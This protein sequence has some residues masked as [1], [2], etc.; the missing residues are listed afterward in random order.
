M[1]KDINEIL[2]E[3]ASLP[4]KKENDLSCAGQG[5][6]KRKVFI[7]K[8][9]WAV[10]SVAL[11]LVIGLGVWLG[12]SLGK[13]SDPVVRYLTDSDY[14]I[15]AMEHGDFAKEWFDLK[16][17]WVDRQ[18]FSVKLNDNEE[19]I[20]FSSNISLY[21]ENGI[22]IVTLR[23]L[24]NTYEINDFIEAN[25]FDNTLVSNNKNVSYS[26]ATKNTDKVYYLS[27]TENDYTYYL[28]VKGTVTVTVQEL[29]DYLL[30]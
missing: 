27:F 26:E 14:H 12:I 10:L 3:Y 13:P 4:M 16:V 28:T 22:D 18:D 11:C 19:I 9:A 29:C 1:K 17:D 7:T 2:N 30:Q 8:Q 20:G 15:E 24:K 5:E 6:V 21:D 25:G 23:G